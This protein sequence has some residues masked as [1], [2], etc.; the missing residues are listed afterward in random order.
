[1]EL[2]KENRHFMSR[3][4][5]TIWYGD[6]QSKERKYLKEN[7]TEIVASYYYKKMVSLEIQNPQR[8]IHIKT[9]KTKRR[10]ILHI[11]TNWFKIQKEKRTSKQTR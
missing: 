5:T 10:Q 8:T 9:V 7:Y 11:Q 4:E 6:T 1:M 3:D 2:K